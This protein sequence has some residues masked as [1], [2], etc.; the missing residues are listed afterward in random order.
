MTIGF[1]VSRVG[2]ANAVVHLDEDS[3]HMHVAGVPVA[4]GYKS[5]LYTQVSK[6]TVFTPER[7]SVLLQGELRE[8]ANRQVKSWFDEQIKAKGKGYNHDLSVVEYKVAK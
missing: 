6:R 3:P 8:F 7:L 1:A 5:G 4:M 2:K